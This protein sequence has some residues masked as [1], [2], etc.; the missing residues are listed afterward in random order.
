MLELT[1]ER[2]ESGGAISPLKRASD[3]ETFMST[4]KVEPATRI[5]PFVV[6]PLT[7][8]DVPQSREIERDAFPNLF[9]PTSFRR[10][11][12]NRMAS[13]LVAHGRDDATSAGR[14][15]SDAAGVPNEGQGRLP[16]ESLLRR[17]RRMLSIGSDEADFVAGFLGAWYMVDEVHIVSV[18]VRGTLRGRGIGEL[19]LIGAIEQ[20]MARDARAVS[21]EVRPSNMV[22]Q[23]LYHKYGFKSRGLRKSYYAD[24]REDAIIMTTDP[25]TEAPFPDLL[26]ALTLAHEHRWG[27]TERFLH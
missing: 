16:P 15:G 13:Y 22:A 24:N 6:R 3:A 26:R 14:P 27:R 19:L 9:P 20:A 7:G 2:R 11:L 25:I 17:A 23:N 5:M 12:K 4:V 18:G 21:L 1:V 8:Q 10:E